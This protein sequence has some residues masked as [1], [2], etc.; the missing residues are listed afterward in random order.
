MLVR[1]RKF[2][3][4]I[5]LVAIWLTVTSFWWTHTK[6]VAHSHA[7]PPIRFIDHETVISAGVIPW[8]ELRWRTTETRSWQT[9]RIMP[10]GL[11]VGTLL[12]VA[13]LPLVRWVWLA[14]VRAG[15]VHG[16]CDECGY[17]GGATNTCPECGR[18]GSPVT[19][20][21]SSDSLRQPRYIWMML[22]SAAVFSGVI[23]IGN[24]AKLVW[25]IQHYHQNQPVGWSIPH[26]STSLGYALLCMMLTIAGLNAAH[27]LRSR[28]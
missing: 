12:A 5:S 17:R 16:Q 21:T 15:Q 1:S 22:L 18:P 24:V 4:G 7:D 8:L 14:L 3:Y 9:W 10:L 11:A 2:W 28:V 26:W 13:L 27:W 20:H 19:L 6:F 23:L 25:Y